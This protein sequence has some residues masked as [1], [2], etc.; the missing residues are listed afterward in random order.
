MGDNM[1]M[2]TRGENDNY[3]SYDVIDSED[4]NAKEVIQFCYAAV[5]DNLLVR[6]LNRK[7][8]LLLLEEYRLKEHL[9]QMPVVELQS[10]LEK[11]ANEIFDNKDNVIC[12]KCHSGKIKV[13]EDRGGYS[14]RCDCCKATNYCRCETKERA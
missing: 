13:F 5:R 11:I 9:S 10:S 2:N 1:K 6:G 7:E 12:K 14:V 4:M 8:V 3:D